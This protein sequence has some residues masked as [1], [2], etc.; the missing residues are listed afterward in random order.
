MPVSFL[1]FFVITVLIHKLMIVLFI[2]KYLEKLKFHRIFWVD[3][4]LCVC[5]FFFVLFFLHKAL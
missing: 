2:L 3:Y 4:F 1:A 5:G